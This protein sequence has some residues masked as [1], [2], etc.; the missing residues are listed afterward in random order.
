[1]SRIRSS[2]LAIGARY[3]LA[4][5]LR[6]VFA[7]HSTASVLQALSYEAKRQLYLNKGYRVQSAPNCYYTLMS[8]CIP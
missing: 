2:V 1:M 5:R 3:A 8:V 7:R 6:S 4:E